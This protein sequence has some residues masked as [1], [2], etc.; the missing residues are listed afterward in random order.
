[1]RI[2]IELSQDACE[3][4]KVD[5]SKLSGKAEVSQYDVDVYELGQQALRRVKISD[6]L[7]K[8]MEGT[9]RLGK[10]TE[11]TVGSGFVPGYEQDEQ[12][13]HELYELRAKIQD[14]ER[15]LAASKAFTDHVV[16]SQLNTLADAHQ[17]I[18]RTQREDL[19]TAKRQLKEY[20][21]QL[22]VHRGKS[23]S[24][25][26]VGESFLAGLLSERLSGITV[27]DMHKK[28]KHADL[29]VFFDTMD[30]FISIESKNISEVKSQ[31]LRHS[32]EAVAHL[33][34]V[35]KDQ[36]IGH[37]FISLRDKNI[38][39]K[40]DFCFETDPATDIPI[41]WMG[42]RDAE[43]SEYE[44]KLIVSA[45]QMLRNYAVYMRDAKS[46]GD[47]MMEGM[48]MLKATMAM[49]VSILG[50]AIKS[51][52][53]VKSMCNDMDRAVDDAQKNV[54]DAFKSCQD[55]LNAQG[56]AQV[57]DTFVKR[58]NQ[59]MKSLG[60]KT[61]GVSR[62]GKQASKNDNDASTDKST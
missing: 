18:I 1:M 53:A 61:K 48:E 6:V 17:E 45:F 50:S 39:G 54:M 7:Q 59:I 22:A 60:P 55:T 43:N 46:N 30:S 32:L 21:I 24:L 42:L 27:R 16:R 47:A 41:L 62:K 3:I 52:H 35:Y 8:I 2:N 31:Q 14:L 38:A 25:G 49:N 58:A 12:D 29:H 34:N 37:M 56:H 15:E 23:S 44:Q 36:Y 10:G 28:P 40:D 19:D 13:A 9:A 26:T 33:K 51:L 20:E 57:K 11:E 5:I 4:R